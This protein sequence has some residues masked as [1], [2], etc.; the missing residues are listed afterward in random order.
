MVIEIFKFLKY[1]PEKFDFFDHIFEY[2][3]KKGYLSKEQ[4]DEL[5]EKYLSPKVK[6]NVITSVQ[7][8]LTKGK[9]EGKTEGEQ[10]KAVKWFCAASGKLPPPIF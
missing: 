6:E 3:T 10:S 2:V 8:W 7:E 5:L 1:Q 4:I 9:T